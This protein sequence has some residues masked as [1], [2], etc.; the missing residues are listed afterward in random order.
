MAFTK[1]FSY[2]FIKFNLFIFLFFSQVTTA[3]ANAAHE[4]FMW[5][6]VGYHIPFDTYKLTEDD[7][8]TIADNGVEWISINFAWRD[9]EPVRNAEFKFDYFDMVMSAAKA[10]GLKVFAQVGNGYNSPLV[11]SSVPNWTIELNTLAYVREL[12]DYATAVVQRYG[13]D[14]DYWA[15]ENEINFA[16]VHIVAMWRVGRWPDYKNDEIMRTLSRVVRV[17]DPDSRIVLSATPMFPGTFGRWLERV[18][19]IIDYDIVGLHLYPS[20][21]PTKEGYIKKFYE[22]SNEAIRVASRSSGGKPI[23]IM[24]TGFHASSDLVGDYK[25]T[26]ENQS[27]YIEMMSKFA[28]DNNLMGVFIYEYLDGPEE[29]LSREQNFGVMRQD[30]TPK[31]AWGVYG[32]IIKANTFDY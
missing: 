14:I 26:E 29:R 20:F 11:R 9:I 15:L 28:L 23:L 18:A 4:P 10:N 27:K 13:A 7:I 16:R 32:D 2:F 22:F 12:E 25:N 31:P 17:H 19:D 30:R 21:N 5:G 8:K 24:E 1:V 3:S 6:L